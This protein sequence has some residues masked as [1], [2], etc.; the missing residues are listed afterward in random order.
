MFSKC[1]KIL[2]ATFSRLL[3]G[4]HGSCM[5]ILATLMKQDSSYLY[6]L[7]GIV[8]LFVEMSM[9][10]QMTEHG[11]WKWFSPMVLLYLS[12]VIPSV[13]VLELEYLRFSVKANGTNESLVNSTNFK[14]F[15]KT[16]SIV[17][18]ISEELTILVLVIGRWLMPRGNMSRDQLAQLL[19]MYLA[20]GAD[21]L[22]ILELIKE[23]SVKN[24]KTT[25]VAGLCLFSLA[26]MQFTLVLT[27]TWSPSSPEIKDN[28]HLQSLSEVKNCILSQCC[29]SEVWSVIIMVGMQD[30]PFLIYRLYLVTVQKVFNRSIFFFIY[31][32]MLA[33]IIQVYRVV[34]FFGN[35]NRIRKKFIHKI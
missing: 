33:V 2:S 11:E 7:T 15:E 10:L 35:Q 24:K 1:R 6:L 26:I 32:N 25:T 27:Q 23:P 9:T 21:I 34:V 19:L 12:S 31:K 13:F 4:L 17:L 18:Q 14:E 20:L 22:D 28:E 30:G 5:V 8:L 29:Q 16:Y 3:L